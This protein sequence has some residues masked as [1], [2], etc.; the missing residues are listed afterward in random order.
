[1]R[2]PRLVDSHIRPFTAIVPTA[3][4]N[5]VPSEWN[6]RFAVE[7]QPHRQKKQVVL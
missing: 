3:V 4:P 7:H 6:M 5:A 1:M 2:F